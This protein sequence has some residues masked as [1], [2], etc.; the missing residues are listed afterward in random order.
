MTQ[1]YKGKALLYVGQHAKKLP[2][3]IG[4][5]LVLRAQFIADKIVE[6]SK[7][8]KYHPDSMEHHKR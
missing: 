7:K 4:H 2:V 3:E 1:M 6:Y 8:A 5:V